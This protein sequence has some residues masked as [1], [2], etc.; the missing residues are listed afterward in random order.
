MTVRT[1]TEARALATSEDPRIPFTVPGRG[2]TAYV[3]LEL[4]ERDGAVRADLRGTAVVTFRP[5]VVEIRTGGWVTRTT[6]EAVDAALGIP[7]AF[8]TISRVP[9]VLGHRMTEPTVLDYTGDRVGPLDL[10]DELSPLA[11]PRRARLNVT[12]VAQD[13]DGTRVTLCDWTY[14]GRDHTPTMRALAAAY[15][16]HPRAR[17]RVVGRFGYPTTEE[18]NVSILVIHD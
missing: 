15:V 8:T 7:R 3:T 16:G 13:R 14:G 12:D 10:N 9:Y 11:D 4:D 1:Y 2:S 17:T 18:P 5:D 6:A